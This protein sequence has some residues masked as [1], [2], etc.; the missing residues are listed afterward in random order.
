M[1]FLFAYGEPHFEQR[2]CQLV[3]PLLL[4]IATQKP[5]ECPVFHKNSPDPFWSDVNNTRKEVITVKVG[6]IDRSIRCMLLLLI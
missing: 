1:T 2:A 3:V 6:I 4:T 5:C